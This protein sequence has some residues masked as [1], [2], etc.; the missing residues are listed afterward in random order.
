MRYPYLCGQC[1]PFEV[2]KGMA[3]AGRAEPCPSCSTVVA[4]QDFASKRL[5][6]FMS[7][8]NNW[9]EGKIVFQLPPTHPDYN[10]TSQRQMEQV[11]KRNGLNMETGKFVSPEAQVKATVPRN[12][13]GK[14]KA[15]VVSGV[16]D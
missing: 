10:V 4:D 6:A 15:R 11:Y 3:E 1:G 16:D 5:G 9:S 12:K 13:R 8:D 2:S 7:R 14:R